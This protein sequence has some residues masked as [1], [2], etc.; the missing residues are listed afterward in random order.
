[1]GH[2]SFKIFNLGILLPLISSMLLVFWIHPMIVKTALLK[3]IVD[4]PDY[5]KLQKTPVP[6]LGGVAVYWGIV[7][8]ADI[9]SMVFHSHALLTSIVAL[10]V[11][12]YIGT[13][14]AFAYIALGYRNTC[15]CIRCLYGSKQYE[16]LSWFIWHRKTSRIPICSALYSR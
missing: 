13:L 3:D 6:V 14:R 15:C 5:R 10:T 16:P 7:I 11:M 12:I 1:M 9:T 2:I 8:G 4:K